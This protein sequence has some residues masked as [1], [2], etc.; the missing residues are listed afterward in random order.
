MPGRIRAKGLAKMRALHS[1]SAL[2][3]NIF[4]YWDKKKKVYQIAH[5]CGLCNKG[6]QTTEKVKFEQKF[7]ISK[8][9]S[10]SPN[11]DVVIENK[12]RA[13]YEIF[14]IECKFSEAYGS[15]GH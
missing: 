6:N 9:F 15:Y 1:S 8:K 13:Q 7:V 4:Q 11:I 2:A 3:V 12:D 10:F 5:A 14:A